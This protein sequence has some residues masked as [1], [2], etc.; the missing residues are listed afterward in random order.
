MGIAIPSEGLRSVVVDP[1]RPTDLYTSSGTAGIWKSTDY[2]NHWTKINAGFGFLAQGLCLA[3]LPTEPAATVLLSSSCGCGKIH[4]STDG[5]LTFRDVGGGLPGDLYSFN[6]DPYNANHIISGFHEKDG[7]AESVDGGETWHLV[8]ATGFPT[9]G[10]SWYPYFV[11]TGSPDTTA[12]TWLAIAQNGGSPAITKDGGAHWTI[13]TGIRGLIHPHGNSQIYQ[14][15]STIFISGQLGEGGDGVYR[16]ADRGD[17]FTKISMKT[18]SA[19]V[20]GTASHVYSMFAWSCYNC[21]ID[22]NFMVG[23]ASGDTWATPGVPKAMLMGADHVAVTSDG[24]HQIFV[25]AMRN[26]GLWRYVEQ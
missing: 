1:L 8:V 13:P 2:G 18:P 5:A 11:D 25:A 19:V 20:W 15:G 24:K 22:P 7:L 6:L 26:S 23:S 4:K 12:K 17:T 16:S 9:G 3:V 14:R 21:P 10:S